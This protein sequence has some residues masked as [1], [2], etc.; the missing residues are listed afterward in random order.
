MLLLRNCVSLDRFSVEMFVS[1]HV[2]LLVDHSRRRH[3]VE[4][5]GTPAAVHQVVTLETETT[6]VT[7]RYIMTAH[8]KHKMLD[9]MM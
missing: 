8:I 2:D 1:D 4:T 5:T 7:R 3:L 9:H 6:T